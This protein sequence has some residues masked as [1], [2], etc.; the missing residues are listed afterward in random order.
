MGLTNWLLKNGPGSPGSTAKVFIREYKKIT[1]GQHN[2]EWEGAFYALFMMRYIA[3]Q[4]L[5]FRGCL[6][7]QTDAN[8]I[9]EFSEGDMG[10][11]I[12]CMMLLETTNFRN[13]IN[14]TTFNDV[15]NVI[16]EVV[17]AEAP[18][19]IIFDLPTFRFK[20]SQFIN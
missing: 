11:F 8:E 10:L 6:L 15:T 20:A 14:N 18:A 9:V 2:E 3:F 16:Y 1:T 12:F 7:G 5:G 19:T 17:R 13:N 4:R